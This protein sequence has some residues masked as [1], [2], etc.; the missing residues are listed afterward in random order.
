MQL[1]CLKLLVKVCEEITKISSFITSLGLKSLPEKE[2][3]LLL[4]SE[5][6]SRPTSLTLSKH[7]P[8]ASIRTLAVIRGEFVW[9]KPHPD[10]KR[11]VFLMEE[12]FGFFY[13]WYTG[14]VRWS[15]D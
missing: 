8:T 3:I 7:S 6:N 9:P 12:I 15:L 5:A 11:V 13:I 10:F 2:L 1:L 14:A 4:R